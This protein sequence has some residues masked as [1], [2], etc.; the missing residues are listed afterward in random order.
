MS[1]SRHIIQSLKR[2]NYYLEDGKVLK[3]QQNEREGLNRCPKCGRPFRPGSNTCMHCAS[4]KKVIKRLWNMAKPYKGFVLC[5]VG[6][7]F[8]VSGLNLFLPYINKIL[9]D[10]YIKNPDQKTILL[11]SFV[12]VIFSMLAVQLLIRGLSMLKSHLLIKNT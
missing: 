10:D 11:S 2:L 12:L 5:S 1:T 9:V 7:F 3:S 6:L 4:K 8:V